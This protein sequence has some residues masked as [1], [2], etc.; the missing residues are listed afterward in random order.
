MENLLKLGV[1]RLIGLPHNGRRHEQSFDCVL[2]DV[3]MPGMDG[4]E[5]LK[6]IREKLSA[7]LL[8][9]VMVTA[10]N[11]SEDV[12]DALK[13]GANDYVTKPVDFP[14]AL[15]RV[16]TQIS[17]RRA[18]LKLLDTNQ[19]LLSEKATLEDRVSERAA[20][21]VQANAA[22]QEEISRRIVSEDKIA[23][24]ARHDTLTGLANRFTFEEELNLAR[25]FAR[26]CGS[27]LSLL[28]IDL[29]GFKNVNDTLGHAIGDE[30]LKVVALRL[31]SV[32]GTKDFCARLGG[33]EFAIVHVSDDARSSAALLAEK[34]IAAISGGHIVDGNQIYI[35]AS[36]GVS[37]L[38]GG[39][40]D[41]SALLRQAD[42]A[43]YRAKAD[44]RGVYRSFETEMG[45]QADIRRSLELDLRK[46]VA[47]G[48]FQLYYHPVID[49]K[50][51]KVTGV[52][53]L[54]RW[55][56][57]AR[58]FVPPVEFIPLAEETGLIVAMGEW[59]LRRAC[60]DAAR[61]S[62]DIRVAVNLS[63]VQFRNKCLVAEVANALN[64]SGLAPDRLELEITENV[65]LGNNSQN[66]AI[67]QA[68]RKL[69]VRI[70]LDDF[71]TGYAGLAYFRAIQFDKVK[72][73]Q[74]FV[75][76]MNRQPECMAIIRAAIALGENLGLTTTAE[77]VES[78]EQME[79]LQREGCKE[80]QGF[81][82]SV[83][84]PNGNLG[85]T[86]DQIG[87]LPRPPIP[88]GRLGSAAT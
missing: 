88:T 62:N 36:I 67:L 46:A 71:G 79:S 2:L 6:R 52:E 23:Y 74:S 5:V 31:T 28:F 1:L 87:C 24:L 75:H 60:A 43:M 84:Q 35:G 30:L 13:S 32:N 50:E 14:I 72:I 48:D 47:N 19:A 34:L 44:G 68:L 16:N 9:V 66:V 80:V 8:P 86:L 64:V 78:V 21:L 49:L 37:T 29:D 40:N 27:Q 65:I 12:V 53:A 17:R 55:N 82:F 63:P 85:H 56:H 42:L 61:W 25:Q 59:A 81:L 70:S 7:S 73:D 39:D 11:Q 4:T 76:E 18:E 83:P 3:M 41:T 51:R 58:G 22:I 45:R 38:Y 15:A 10:K 57:P 26:E 20:R 69:G 33:D 54:M 77:G